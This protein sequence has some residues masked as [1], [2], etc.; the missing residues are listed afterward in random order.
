MA[1]LEEISP[2]ALIRELAEILASG[3]L[4][5]RSREANI[6]GNTPEIESQV[7]VTADTANGCNSRN[8]PN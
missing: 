4:R 3:F 6:G 5:L 1:H 2:E 7:G 8:V